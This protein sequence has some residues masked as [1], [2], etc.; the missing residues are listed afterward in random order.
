MVAIDTLEST[1]LEIQGRLDSTKTQAERNRLGQFA[2]PT[3]LARDIIEYAKSLLPRGSNIRFLDPAFG[4]GSFYSAL[5]KV[6]PTSRIVMAKGYEIDSYYGQR[7]RELWADTPLELH[8]GDFTQ[9]CP[10]N[11]QD[12]KASLLICNPPYVRHH[13]LSE[14][15]KL[16]LQQ[17]TEETSGVRLNGLAGLYCYFICLSRAW[18]A[19]DGLAGWLIPSEFMD[20]NYGR[21]IKQ[22]LVN[23]VT[24]LRI[25]RFDPNDVQFGDALVSSAV[26]WF[27]K[28][29]PATG[30][31]VEFTYGGTLSN[32]K[33][34]RLV[35][36]EVLRNT[37]K[38]TRFPLMHPDIVPF[39]GIKLGDLFEVKRGLATGANNFFVLT[40]EQADEYGIPTKFLK[41]ILPSPRYLSVNEIKAARDGNPILDR[42]LFL[43]TCELPE[44]EVKSEYPTLWKYLQGGIKAGINDGYLCRHRFPWYLQEERPPSPF[45]CTYMGRRDTRAARAFRFILNHSKA[46]AANVYLLLYPKPKMREV[47]RRNP[48]L[49]KKIWIA[50]NEIPLATLV[51]E[52]RVYGGGLHKME[53][54]E[55]ANVPA[56][57]I[58]AV[59]S[60]SSK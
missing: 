9:A 52:G 32:P 37:A 49:V 7:A 22:Y 33:H 16:R 27:R 20:V 59:L 35:S 6:F 46:T 5:L 40:G 51:S 55:L 39:E 57:H 30:H 28:A 17:A 25:H 4:T 34:S 31:R 48:K 14:K 44:N 43:V 21:Q 15:D 11:T 13:H 54:S 3:L 23:Q 38:W 26:V 50:L 8:I 10:P 41:P 42:K 60:K 56:D 53:P 12:T 45:L 36:L 2:T 18:M 47:F 58:F 24:L 19:D 1:R 29:T